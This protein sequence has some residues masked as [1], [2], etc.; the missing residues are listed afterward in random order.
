MRELPVALRWYLG[1]IY[2]ACLALIAAQARDLP[3][4]LSRRDVALGVLVFGALAY[5]GG[6]AGIRVRKGLV[7]TLS[8]TVHIASILVFAPPLPVLIALVATVAAQIAH[9]RRP[10]YKRLFNICHDVLVVGVCSLLV[11]HVAAPSRLLRPGHVVSALALLGLLLALYYVLDVGIYLGVQALLR[12]RAPWTMW[13]EMYRHTIFAELASSAIGILGAVAWQ[14]DHVL[15]ALVVVPVIALHVTFRAIV[16]AENRAMALEQVFA[17]GKH[18]QLRQSEAALLQPVS[19]AALTITAASVASVYLPDPAQPDVLTRVAYA[20]RDAFDAGPPQ[21]AAPDTGSGIEREKWER[22]RIALVPIE[23]GDSGVMALL[24]L[25]GVPV[26]P[27]DDVRDALAILVTQTTIGLRNVQLHN[28]TLAQVSEDGLTGLLNRRYF[29]ARLEEEVARAQRGRQ[30]LALIRLDLDNFAHANAVHGA[31]AGDATLTAVAAALRTSIPRPG[32]VARYEGDEFAI[33]LPETDIDEAV[34]VARRACRDVAALKIIAGERTVAIGVSAGVAALPTHG[35]RREDLIRSA[36][37]ALYVAKHTGKGR[38]CRPEEAVVAETLDATVLAAR[39]EHANMATVE[40]LA[41]AV[42]AKDP[43][44]RGHSQRVSAYAAAVAYA[45]G[46][47]AGEVARVRLAGL[48]HDV[49]KIGVPD[50]ILTKPAPLSG[51]EFEVIRRHAE[52]GERLLAAAPF[53]RDVLPAVRHHHERWDGGGYPD[54][55]V[56]ATI[57]RDAAILMVADSFDAMTSSRTYRP[58][59]PLR[60]A[61]R[62]L[63]EG[64]GTQ[65]DARIVAALEQAIGEGS[66]PVGPVPTAQSTIIHDE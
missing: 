35:A 39:L 25:S 5:A 2:L 15:I 40:A 56:G 38:V 28:R 21:L 37:H 31:Q 32:V 49:G 34:E 65:F 44:T 62:R 47:S 51:A 41:A 53:L 22:D 27:W 12:A 3:A 24:R 54:G 10:L 66:L 29:Q 64:S 30:P 20:P 58:A 26:Q 45:L 63:R 9:R 17:A 57:P 60:E 18:A 36:D 6:Y 61:C 14:Y 50:A 8:T 16:Q 19:E 55:L 11:S 42:D 46:L 23:M 33:M 1:I 7:Q 4:A 48:L 59:L 52:I 13:A 43:Y